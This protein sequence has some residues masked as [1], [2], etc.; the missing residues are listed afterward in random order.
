MDKR[1]PYGFVHDL[2]LTYFKFHG[3][4]WFYPESHYSEEMTKRFGWKLD[5]QVFYRKNREQV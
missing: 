4:N 1:K 2:T 3:L 5:G